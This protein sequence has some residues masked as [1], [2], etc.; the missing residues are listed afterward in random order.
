ENLWRQLADYARAGG[1]I[2]IFLGAGA[3]QQFAS[4]N[5]EAAQ[6]L[7]PGPLGYIGRFPDGTN[8]LS[9]KNDQHPILAKFRPRRGAVPWEDFPVYRFWQ[10][11]SLADGVGTVM[12]LAGGQP[13][14]LERPLGKGRVLTLTTPVSELA[15][16]PEDER[17]NQ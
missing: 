12:S 14:L 9:T 4:F 7:L 17:W 6:E 13:A 1:G 15:E 2:G 3:E 11:E 8:Y 10:F 5:A 16:V